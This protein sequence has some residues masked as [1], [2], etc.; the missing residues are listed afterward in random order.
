RWCLGCCL[1]ADGRKPLYDSSGAVEAEAATRSTCADRLS[2]RYLELGTS[3][4]RR[5]PQP[6]ICR[7][8]SFDGLQLSAAA[9][10]D[11]QLYGQRL[12]SGWTS[13]AATKGA[14]VDA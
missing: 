11:D 7:S 13:S 10:D 12:S 5:R 14:G 9:V 3:K 6:R 1:D 8:R 4:R 2:R